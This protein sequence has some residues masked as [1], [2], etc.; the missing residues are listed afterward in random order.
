MFCQALERVHA[1]DARH[2]RVPDALSANLAG[3]L[4]TAAYAQGLARIDHVVLG[5]GA[6][7][8]FAVQGD[9][10]SPLRQIACVDVIQAVATPLAQ[11][12]AEFLAA[13]RPD[14]LQQAQDMQLQPPPMQ[15]SLE[16]MHR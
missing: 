7:R 4:A 3:S 14:G 1:I 2:G 10:R 6:T 12:S 9:P 5:E 13:S 8:A 15:A 16:G 11:S